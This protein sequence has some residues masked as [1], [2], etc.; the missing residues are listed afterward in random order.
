MEFRS[1]LA[2][3]V[4][5]TGATAFLLIKL[6]EKSWKM[7]EAATTTWLVRLWPIRMPQQSSG[8][9]VSSPLPTVPSW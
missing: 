8:T 9:L 4:N 2:L 7:Q 5:L 3:T 6:D 1:D